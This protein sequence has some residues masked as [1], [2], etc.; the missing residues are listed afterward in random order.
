MSTFL[1]RALYGLLGLL[2]LV[3]VLVVAVVVVLQFP[4]GQDF[5]ARRAESYLRGKLKTEVRI[6]KFRTDFRHA[7]NLDGVYL[8]DQQRDTLLSVGHL[9]VDLDILALLHSQINVSNVELNDG[10]VRLTRTEPDSVNN[11]DFIIDAFVDPNAPTD[12]TASK[13]KYDIGKLRLT[14]IYFTQNDQITG[15]DVRAR[16]GELTVN[17]DEVDVD[18]SIYKVDNVALRRASIAIVQTKTAPEVDNPAPTEPLTLQFGLNKATLDSVA[19]TYKNNPAAQFISTN[20]GLADITARNIDLRNERIDLTKLTLKNTRFAYA[21]NENVPVEE[22]VVNPAEAVRKLDEAADKT[23]A[24]T[25]Q[26]LKWRVTLAQSDISGLDVAFDN[27][28]QPKQRTRLPAMDYNHLHFSDLV[29]NT[30][31][32][33]F[34]ENRTTAKVDNLAGREQSGFLVNKWRANV[35]YDSVQIRLDSLDLITPHTRIRRTLAIGYES[36]AALGNSKNLPNLKIEGDLRNVRLGFRDILY[37]APDLAGTSPFNTGPNQSVLLNGQIAGRVGDFTVR[38]LEFVGLRNTVLRA[39]R[40]RIQGLPNV[41]SRL[42]ADLDIQQF[43]T[44]EADIR[45]LAPKGSIPTNISIPP[46][47]AV[48]GTFRGRPTTLQFNTNLQLRSTYGDMAFSGN[49]GAAQANGRQPVVGTFATKGFDFGRL[50]KNP[51]LGRVTATGRINATGNLKDPGTLVGQVNANV[52]SARYNGY[53]YHGVVAKVDLDRN[54]FVISA[55]SKN[56]P[57][58]NLDLQAVVNLR[59]PRNPT[60]EVTSLNL[61]GANLTALGFYT[62]GDLR[63]QGNLNANLSGSN[64]NTLNG[65]FSGTNVVLV[66]DN[67]PF[68]FDTLRGKITQTA[69]RAAL[70]FTSNIVAAKLDGNVH[71]GDL[72]PELEQHIDRYFDLPGVRYVPS[73]ADRHFTY[74]LQLKDGKLATK[75]VPGLKQISPF[76][77]AGDYSRQ[78][79]RLTANTSIPIIRYN[80]Y[81]IDSLRLNVDSDASKLDYGLRMAQAA[82]DTTLKLRRPSIIGNVANNK[83]FTRAAILGDSS[84]R[85]RLA[86]AGTLQSLPVPGSRDQVIY[87]FSAAPEQVLNYQNWTAG[88]NNYVRYYPTGAVVADG[89]RLTNGRSSLALQSQNPAVP[90]SPLGVTFTNFEL[91]ELARIVQQQDSLVAGTLNGTA[92]IDNL[93]TKRQAFTADATVSNLV[94]QKAA[95]GDIALRATNPAPS[96]YDVDARL[97]GGAAGSVGGSGNDVHLTGTYLASSATPLNFTVDANRLNLKLVEPFSVGQ[98]RSATGFVHG[99]LSVTGAPA[100]PQIRGTLTTSDDAGFTVPQLGSPFRLPNQDLT[101]DNRGIAFHDF[102]VLDSA[103]NKAVANGYLLTKD[104]INYSFDMRATTNNFMAVRSTRANNELFYGRLVLDSDTRLTGPVSLIKVDTRV[105]VVEGSNLTVESPN[106]TPTAVERAG[107]VEFIDKSAP[108]DTML[109]RKVA[110]DTTKVDA[111]G[112][113]LTAVVTI[114]DRTPFT[115]VIDP[116]SGDN[117]RVRAA[118]TLN[119]NIAPDGTITLSG[120][121]DVARGQYHMSLYDLAS[122]DFII[123]RGSSITWDGDPYNADLNVTALYKVRAAPAELLSGQGLD[124][125]TSNTLARNRLP[126][127]VLLNVTDQISKPTIGFD[128]TLPE[129]QRGALGGQVEAKLAQLRQPNQ[130]SEMSKQVFSLLVLGRF[131][132][133]NPFQTSSG[134]GV[135]ASQLRGS[136]SA[137]LTDQLNNITDKYLSGLGLDLGL[138]NQADYSSGEARSR[139]DLNVAVRRQLLNNRLT[140]RV[141]TDIALSGNTGTQTTTG[142]TPPSNLTGDVSLEYSLLADGRLRVR[143]FRQNAYEDIDGQIVRTGAGLVFQREYRDLADLF[144]KVPK[145]VKEERKENRKQE[146]VDKKAEQD[147]VQSQPTA[148]VDTS[149]VK[150]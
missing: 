22:R 44:T 94:F 97:T 90:T 142:Q 13:L 96:R 126:F 93:G 51:Q 120:R 87:Q 129:N 6:G 103:S 83:V 12:T 118:G 47:L 91:A 42:Y 53:N 101:F 30:R 45:S 123:R 1:R 106:A 117:L 55:N 115:I 112:Y 92:R 140:V 85:E 108:L 80:N 37:L 78:A 99:Q 77:L 52:Q 71:L 66:R 31:D 114:N 138:T 39:R 62:G 107:I 25:G 59:D 134:E 56:D 8:A 74:S 149:R 136:A 46:S 43:S 28:N 146:K 72:A 57:N 133:Q 95:I 48:S 40:G 11:Y 60:Y 125:A 15:S 38:N 49:L 89:L 147:S 41:D 69:T 79:A 54:R 131:V 84:T 109:A 128:I 141:G 130:N 110:L 81:R 137:V 143:V 67:Q 5:V 29:L 27:F 50:L 64:L 7:I 70:D 34:S 124:D 144:S 18:K 65:T 61:R 4:A 150:K 24:A 32:F 105:T 2:A 111:T 68:A 36:L 17:M 119:T 148:R 63:V 113:D 82:Q 88:A 73:A 20:I 127:N 122:R 76:T 121:L 145:S 86:L 139:T 135:V 3:L 104:F 23:K 16:L 98:V 26:P 116:V 19:F 35:V 132:A 21:Q 58:L 102:T 33:S 9:G 14:N 75:L 10:R 100:T